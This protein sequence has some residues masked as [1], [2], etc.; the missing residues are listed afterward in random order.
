[1]SWQTWTIEDFNIN[2]N[3][4]PETF[5][6]FGFDDRVTEKLIELYNIM[7][8]HDSVLHT[9]NGYLTIVFR[10]SD[11]VEKWYSNVKRKKTFDFLKDRN[12]DIMHEILKK[13]EE[14]TPPHY[15][16]LGYA[17]LYR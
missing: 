16:A 8:G 10:P 7:E 1:M 5:R 13:F 14:E 17:T 12:V 4:D 11:L 15:V 2:R 6:E 3:Y 9:I